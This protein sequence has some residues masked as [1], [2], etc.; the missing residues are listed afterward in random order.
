M[1]LV[2]EII[3]DQSSI[4]C[5]CFS[6]FV[7]FSLFKKR[8][9]WTSSMTGGPWTKSMKVVLGLAPNKSLRGTQ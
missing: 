4:A 1:D 5:C 9:P 6:V 7:H 3:T 2:F 8:C